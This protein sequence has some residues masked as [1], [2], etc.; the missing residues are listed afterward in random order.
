M[1]IDQYTMLKN[2]V[3]LPNKTFQYNYKLID[4]SKDQVN[5][6]MVEK[7]LFPGILQNVK[8]SPDMEE[9]RKENVILNYNY[10]DKNGVFVT[11]YI[12]TPEMYN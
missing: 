4:V 5:L 10:E 11:K 12:V 9:M 2:T 1:Q 8:T 6:D 7:Y 3:A